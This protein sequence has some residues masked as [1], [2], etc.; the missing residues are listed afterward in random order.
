MLTKDQNIEAQHVKFHTALMAVSY[1]GN[2]EMQE[3]FLEDNANI[4]LMSGNGVKH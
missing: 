4:N 3:S 2:T 1:I